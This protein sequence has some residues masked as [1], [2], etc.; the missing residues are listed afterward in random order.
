[1]ERLHTQITD[2]LLDQ[3]EQERNENLVDIDM[4]KSVI[5]MYQFLSQPAISQEGVNCLNELEKKL[6]ISSRTFFRQL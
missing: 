3:I 5:G 4:L 1:M 2:A 6:L